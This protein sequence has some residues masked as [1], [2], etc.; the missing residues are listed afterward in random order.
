M[1]DLRLAAGLLFLAVSACERQPEPNLSRLPKSM[2]KEPINRLDAGPW[3][4]CREFAPLVQ[5]VNQGLLTNAEFRRGLKSVY[6]KARSSPTSEVTQASAALLRTFT[7]GGTGGDAEARQQTL[8]LVA[9][10]KDWEKR[11]PR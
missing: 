1:R 10:C 11:P 2:L 6:E 9:A 4:A 5:D 7:T 8:A 3:L